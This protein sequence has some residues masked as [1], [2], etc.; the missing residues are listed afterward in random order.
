MGII[1]KHTGSSNVNNLL[2]II[3]C[4]CLLMGIAAMPLTAAQTRVRCFDKNKGLDKTGI[5][6]D[7]SNMASKSYPYTIEEWIQYH[8]FFDDGIFANRVLHINM[9][10]N[11][12]QTA[13]KLPKM[14]SLK[15]LSF[16]YNNISTIED[17][18]F[19]DL[20]ALE[21]LDL[22]FNLLNSHELRH[23][24]F[25]SPKRQ[26]SRITQYGKEA[27][28]KV[29]KLNFNNIHSLSP[30]CFEYLRKLEV[31]ELNYNPLSVIDENTE[32]ALGFLTNLQIL[33]LGNTDIME[34]PA[35]MFSGL[36]NVR[37]LYLNGN[38]FSSIPK[39]IRYMPLTFL[40]MNANPIG[41]LDGDSFVGMDTLEQL[42]ISSM[43]KLTNIGKGTFAPLKKLTTLRMTHN[44]SLSNID[45]DA[46]RDYRF[47][48]MSLKKLYLSDTNITSIDSML[49]PWTMLDLFDAKSNRW[50][51][52]CR[53]SWLASYLNDTFTEDPDIL[54][55]Y[56]CNEPKD[57]N[58]TLVSQLNNHIDCE[59]FNLH[60]SYPNHGHGHVT[61]LR[62]FI[63]VIG[64]VI[65]IFVFGTLI[66]MGCR[67]LGRILKPKIYV[68][69][70]FSTGVKYRPADFEDNIDTSGIPARHETTINGR[71]PIVINNNITD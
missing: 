52:D 18:A 1:T 55:Y 62:H 33:D 39:E 10:N 71:P 7:C 31:L 36:S 27:P 17:Q 4:M 15:K 42:M 48:H 25:Y 20:P 61:R 51:C 50:T 35:N 28:L 11:N 12:F 2:M 58:G 47:D 59:D 53:L 34:F 37:T 21:E 46:F 5:I 45:P 3:E 30:D 60:S 65:G 9:E 67:E 24:V 56:R 40:N 57:L 22:S 6:L 70:R 68:P 26:N 8:A 19:S 32:I 16:K 43:L 66:N 23:D 69:A 14:Q 13:F 63:I 64:L 29:L 38:R 54:L 49:Y 44:P 41:E